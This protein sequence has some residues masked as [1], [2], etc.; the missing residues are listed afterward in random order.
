MAYFSVTTIAGLAKLLGVIP[1]ELNEVIQNR[2]RYYRTIRLAKPDGGSRVLRVPDDRLKILQSR[3]KGRIL[4]QIPLLSCVHGG[5]KGRSVFTNAKPHIGKEIVFTMD[6]QDFFPSV[7]RGMVTTIYDF[8]GF[9]SEALAM[10]VD[11]TT[12]DDQLPQGT[13]TSSAL[14]NLAM[15]RVDMRQ[16]CMARQNGFAYTRYIDDLALS[17]S[18]RLLDFRGMVQRIVEEQG[19]TINPAKIRTMP[20]STRQVVTKIVVNQKLN[21]P[22]ERYISIRRR[23]AEVASSPTRPSPDIDVIRGQLSWLSS[24]NPKKG[25]RLRCR[26][27]SAIYLHGNKAASLKKTS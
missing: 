25:L 5:V 2:G 8:L 21:L 3:I 4:D 20:A 6:I 26:M 9:D 7:G 13:P 11:A 23:V 10:L 15:Y 19:F 12:W 24:V 17:G 22:R 16:S 27:E 1:G 18:R 14:A